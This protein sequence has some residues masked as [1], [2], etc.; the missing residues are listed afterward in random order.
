MGVNMNIEIWSD[1][2]CPFCY[3]GKRHLE[4]ALDQFPNKDMVEI[5]YRSFELDSNQPLY[6]GNKIQELLSKKYG[7]SIEDAIKSTEHIGREARKVGLDYNFDEM[8]Y[9]NTFDAHRLAKYAKTVG[10]EKQIIE[11]IL[12]AFFTESKLISDHDT[13]IQLAQ[14]EGLDKEIVMDVL[15]DRTKFEHDVR[16]DENLARQMSITGVPYII[17]N[18]KHIISGAQPIEVFIET[19]KAAW[20]EESK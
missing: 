7:M 6:S 15:N 13:L 17:I 12:Y 20:E 2:V 1:F 5:V 3:L 18:Q 10:K 4:Y 16:I 14:S 9:T 11:R 8:K 19:I